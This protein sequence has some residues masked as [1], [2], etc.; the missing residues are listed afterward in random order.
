MHNDFSQKILVTGAAGF[1]GSNFINRIAKNE[2][3]IYFLAFD[4]LTYAGNIDNIQETLDQCNNID[5]LKGDI[6]NTTLLE[7]VFTEYN[8]SGVLNFAAES[9]VDNSILSPNVFV[10]TNVVGTLNLLN[11]AK[12]IKGLRYLQVSTDEVYGSLLEGEDP[13]TEL[14]NIRP[15]SPYSASKASADMLVRSYNETYGLDTIIT[16]CSN[17]Y[18]PRQ[19]TEKLIPLMITNAM[20]GK[21]LPV[22]GDG[23]N[24]RDWIHVDDHNDGIWMAYNKGCSGEVYNF[25]GD[26]E[27]RNIDIVKIIL[28]HLQIDHSLIEFVR[29]RLGHDWRYAIDFTKARKNFDWTPK[30]S[31]DDGIKSTIDWYRGN[32]K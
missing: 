6:R 27:K 9:H 7:Q 32:L 2:K 5:F 12:N 4:S 31:F 17:N 19:L 23:M 20:N 24:I 16:R 15:N 11:C 30:R 10:E 25:G 14:T 1:I 13:F 29:D 3:D 21:R 22:Y 18:G 8:F 26:C 28:D